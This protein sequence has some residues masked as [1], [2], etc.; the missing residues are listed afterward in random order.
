M[1]AGRPM[2]SFLGAAGTVT[3]SKFL[4]TG[5]SSRLLVDAGLFQGASRAAAAE[6]GPPP[7]R[8]PAIIDG[9]RRSPTPTSTTAATCPRSS[10][11]GS[12]ARSS[13]T[14]RT[15]E[16][17]GDRPPGQRPPPGGGRPV[18]RGAGLLQAR[19]PRPLYDAD[20]VARV[21]PLF[22]PGRLRRRRPA[23]HR[24]P[25]WSCSRRGTSSARP[26]RSSRS[27]GHR[28]VFSGDLGRPRHPLLGSPVV[29]ARVRHRRRRVDLRQPP[30]RER[31]G[32]RPSAMSSPGPIARGGV[33]LIPAFAVDRTEVVLMALAELAGRRGRSPGCPSTSTA[34]WRWPPSRCTAGPLLE[35]GPRP[36]SRA[37]PR[38]DPRPGRPPRGPHG[39]AVDGPQ[40]TRPSLH[41]RVRLRD[42]HRGPG[43]APPPL[44]CCPT[45]PA[46]SSSS[47]TRRR[48][49]AA[50][51]S[52]RVRRS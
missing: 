38:D 52:P 42:G 48:G 9:G 47:A 36:A 34:R 25:R 1:M 8:R 11:R 14:A 22:T 51:T 23:P 46:P 30:P 12:R 44:I 29:A 7:H 43:G 27:T 35:H 19:P 32:R 3:G 26:R 10:T 37:R 18:C 33:V 6:L 4:V 39:G 28:V 5:R 13:T 16:L 41:R 2:L 40:P 17:A 15:A 20:D 21:L 49:P 50:G 31:P 24:G 45:R